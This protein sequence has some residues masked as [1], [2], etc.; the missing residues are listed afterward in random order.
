M[1]R[2]ADVIPSA[3]LVERLGEA[4]E[5]A[6]APPPGATVVVAVS[7]GLDSC[8]L[9]HLLRFRGGG[10]YRL[11]AAHFDHA[12]RPASDHDALWV[13]GLCTAWRVPLRSERAPS[14]RRT[15]TAARS[16]RYDFLHRVRR[17][18]SATAILTA[19]H[20]DDQAETVLFRILRGTGVAGLAGIPTIREP[21]V[22]RPLL[23]VW[24]E[25]LAQYAADVGL[26]WRE[27]ASNDELG[28]S[29]NAIR[30]RILPEAERLVAPA[31]R[32]ALVRLAE[33]AAEDEAAWGAVMQEL[34]G[35]TDARDE[36]D[37]VSLDREAFL[38]LHPAV[39]ARA[40]RALARRMG[41]VLDHRG[42]RLAVEFSSS[43]RSGGAIWLGAG[44]E[45]TRRLGRLALVR[46]PVATADRALEIADPGPGSGDA[47]VGGRP[48]RVCWGSREVE[49]RAW[50]ET[51]DV[52]SDRL[53][54]VVRGR[55]PGDRIRLP[56]G[57]KKL[58]KLF[59]ECRIPH[60]RRDEVPVVVDAEG[61]VLWV[62]GIARSANTPRGGDT[63]R[64]RIGIGPQATDEA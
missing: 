24:R 6:S 58:K 59:L 32:R 9:L 13:R 52:P 39:R 27:D 33:V 7:G 16:A 50:A 48:V 36:R 20:A 37:G 1:T 53:P 43:G 57:T 54:I 15:E 17:E 5:A 45:L 21:G 4:L 30:R 8:V 61:E 47:W 51:L 23:G 2:S 19:H 28:F 26:T 41:S 10:R 22:M 3:R 44:V 46:R 62:P 34:L 18:V 49:S 60:D 29:R 56:G 40:L 38:A 12:A 42:T 11:V 35:T 55:R 25:E 63:H 14:A 31:A 64:L